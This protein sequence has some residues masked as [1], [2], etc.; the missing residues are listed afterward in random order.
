[1]MSKKNRSFTL[2]EVMIAIGVM[3]VVT[4]MV[5]SGF[6][7]YNRTQQVN[8]AEERLRQVFQEARANAF[9]GKIDCA[10]CGGSDGICNGLSGDVPLGGWRVTVGGSGYTLEGY[11]GGNS[12][13][14]RTESYGS[15]ITGTTTCGGPVIFYASGGTNLGSACSVTLTQ[16]GGSVSTFG[17]SG[18]GF[19][20]PTPS[21][22]PTNTPMP[23]PTNT[24][25]PTNTPTP[26]NTP[27]PTATPTPR[28]P[29]PTPTPSYRMTNGYFINPSD[30]TASRI[31]VYFTPTYVPE[32][33]KDTVMVYR[34]DGTPLGI[35]LRN[36]Q[37]GSRTVGYVG[38]WNS[39]TVF[40][41]YVTPSCLAANLAGHGITQFKIRPHLTSD[42]SSGAMFRLSPNT[43]STT[44]PY[45][46]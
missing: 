36:L 32:H 45:Q 22:A 17:V 19:P 14:A 24:P 39:A 38:S 7:T 37:C 16:T 4:S 44:S 40:Q 41:F 21:A 23:T 30:P 34:T 33:V 46:L 42:P 35:S 9:A 43:F 28:P 25:L 18:D 12:F 10:V 8:A 11:C 31:D 1:M 3:L 2:I 15:G 29:T 13:L 5:I 27:M 6:G 26:T 20:T